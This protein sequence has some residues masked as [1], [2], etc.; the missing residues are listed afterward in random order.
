MQDKKLSFIAANSYYDFRVFGFGI[1]YY[2]AT[3]LVI[4]GY[5]KN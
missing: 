1:N 2:F 5:S 3:E 4:F